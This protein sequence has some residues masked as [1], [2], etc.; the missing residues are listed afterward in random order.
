MEHEYYTSPSTDERRAWVPIVIVLGAVAL[1]L[2]G[3]FLAFRD[4]GPAESEGPLPSLLDPTRQ[5]VTP[6]PTLAPTIPPLVTPPVVV[7][8]PATSDRDD[9]SDETD[10]DQAPATAHEALDQLVEELG[11]S[12]ATDIVAIG[13]DRY[14]LLVVDDDAALYRWDVDAWQ[15]D[16]TVD[17]PSGVRSVEAG[18]VTDDGVAD[19]L[20]H[21]VGLDEAGGVYSR[22][23]F[24][25][26]LLP[27][28]LTSGQTDWVPRL[29]LDLGRL[30]S[31]VESD[32]GGRV[33][34]EWTWTGRQFEVLG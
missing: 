13:S 27:F 15:L 14:A 10:L 23:T 16:D 9:S 12:D 34:V 22:E 20:V 18:D 5:T 4:D 28:N 7:V 31:D 21:L 24:D 17:T 2:G 11:A 25:F 32:A 19:F 33:T 29:E 6:A 1:V 30:L 8:P 3:L 26:Q